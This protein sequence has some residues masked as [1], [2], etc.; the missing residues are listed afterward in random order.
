[1]K[2]RGRCGTRTSSLASSE[3]AEPSITS[4]SAALF[5]TAYNCPSLDEYS[6]AC[7]CIT[8][9]DTTL[10]V[11]ADAPVST[12][13]IATTVIVTIPSTSVATV[14]SLE[15]STTYVTS[16]M[17]VTQQVTT[18]TTSTTT[19]TS[20]S[21]VLAPT[22]T[23]QL[24][25]GSGDYKGKLIDVEATRGY[26]EYMPNTVP[27]NIVFV[28]GG[29]QP[30]LASNPNLK[31]WAWWPGPVSSGINFLTDADAKSSN[32][33]PVICSVGQDGQLTCHTEPGSLTVFAGCNASVLMNLATW[34]N[35]ECP[36][37]LTLYLTTL[38]L[39]DGSSVQVQLPN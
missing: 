23:A 4:T 1:M 14:T 18:P 34:P 17:T 21:L 32:S 33:Q 26:V 2:K 13:T 25:I 36:L 27:A 7:A 16:A 10:S 8:A 20:T 15:P 30:Y 11:T 3:P 38:K 12:S 39:R 24:V 29:G 35:P 37:T 9:V 5:P 31:L 6:S 22:Q 19:V 28:A